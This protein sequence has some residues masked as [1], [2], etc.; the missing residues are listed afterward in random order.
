MHINL[1]ATDLT[2][3]AAY[4]PC[5][6]LALYGF[7]PNTGGGS[8]DDRYIQF[9]EKPS[10]ASSDVPAVKS[11]YAPGGTG[12]SYGP[13]AIGEI[14]LSELTIAVS[15]AQASYTAPGAGTALN[16]T[17]EIETQFPVTSGTTTLVGDLTTGVGSRQIWAESA[18]P[19]RLLR[20]DVVNATVALVPVY[21]VIQAIDAGATDSLGKLIATVASATTKTYHFGRGGGQ[22]EERY[23][24]GTS[25]LV[26][27]G[28]T[29]LLCSSPLFASGLWTPLATTDCSI[30]AVYE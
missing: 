26:R 24:S 11:L 15:T 20:L 7:N 14:T 30:R 22:I 13:G 16:F 6:V 4:G 21:P 23:K 18:G 12:F 28:C 17:V 5:R 3:W 19:K 25:Y 9:H 29:I 8:A 10:V 2:K 1:L 27:R